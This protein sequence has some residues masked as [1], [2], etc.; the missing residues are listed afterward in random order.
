M[1]AT[2]AKGSPFWQFSLAYYRMPGVGPACIEVQD[3]AGVDVNLVLFLLWSA[4][5]GRSFTGEEIAAL[6]RQI[7]AWRNIAVIPI[8]ELRRALRTPPAVLDAALAEGFRNKI[9]AVELEAERLQQEATYALAQSGQYGRP[10]S[11]PL[12]AAR[13]NVAAYQAIHSKAF[14][15]AAIDALLGAFA[16][17]MARAAE[18]Q[19][20]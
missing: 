6:D 7:G 1:S 15:Q 17:F 8:R 11:A 3:Q 19:P 9:K 20:A 14:P 12:A 10:G 5:L 2:E 4:S 13:A 16:D 18:R